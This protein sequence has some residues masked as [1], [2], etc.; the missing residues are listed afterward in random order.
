M[1]FK[2]KIAKIK[3]DGRSLD[4]VKDMQRTR[5]WDSK[6]TIPR[7]WQA[8]RREGGDLERGRGGEDGTRCGR[9]RGSAGQ[10][11]GAEAGGH[12]GGRSHEL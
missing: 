5:S 1:K 10:V 3:V 11:H 9:G 4:K 12:L 6:D 2:S 7:A 8:R